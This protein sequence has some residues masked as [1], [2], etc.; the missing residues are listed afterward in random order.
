MTIRG[1]FHRRGPF[2]GSGGLSTPV[3]RPSRRFWRTRQPLSD[4]QASPWVTPR[5]WTALGA[6]Y[7]ETPTFR[8]TPR[9][10]ARR[11]LAAPPRP[12]FTRTATLLGALRA[13]LFE[14]RRCLP[15]S[16]TATDVRAFSSG[17]RFL[18]GTVA[19]TTFLV[20]RVTLDLSGRPESGDARRAAHVRSPE[21]RCRFLLLTQVCPTAMP[22]RSPYVM[23]LE[24]PVGKDAA[25]VSGPSEGRVLVRGDAGY[26][27][28][29]RVRAPGVR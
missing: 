5:S 16:A 22:K 7:A 14:A 9:R 11:S 15:T 1:A 19:M 26:A 4:V 6:T 12:L 2:P 20:V 13:S 24:H 25:R 21:P 28:P 23:V 29:R 27:P 10:V 8:S 3:P 18:A 17:P